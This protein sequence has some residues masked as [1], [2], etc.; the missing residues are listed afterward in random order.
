MKPKRR[1]SPPANGFNGSSV[2]F[3]IMTE[4]VPAP[5]GL[6]LKFSGIGTFAATAATARKRDGASSAKRNAM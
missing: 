4:D 5:A 3:M 2:P 1:T 6:H